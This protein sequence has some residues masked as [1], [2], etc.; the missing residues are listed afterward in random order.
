MW[1]KYI[2]TV[3]VTSETFSALFKGK[4]KPVMPLFE[5]SK[6]K[7]MQKLKLRVNVHWRLAIEGTFHD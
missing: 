4:S 1:R 7:R 2:S 6:T 3:S 5:N